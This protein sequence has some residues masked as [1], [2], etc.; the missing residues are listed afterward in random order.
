MVAVEPE[1]YVPP[2]VTV[3][4]VKGLGDAVIV[5]VD[6]AEHF[7]ASVIALSIVTDC[8]VAVPV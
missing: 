6:V 7:A 8:E 1:L 2:P 4:P 5:Y 3:P